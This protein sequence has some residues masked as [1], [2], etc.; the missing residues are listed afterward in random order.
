MS[1]SQP[2]I[3]GYGVG[4]PSIK[5]NPPPIISSRAPT[6]TD[7]RF[8]LGQVWVYQISSS[9]ASVYSLGSVAAGTAT[10]VL[11]GG[12]SGDVQTINNLSPT[13]GNITIAG[14]ANQVGVSNAGS[15]V[16]L[17]LPAAITAPGSL[18]TT[19]SLA[20][21]TT[22]TAG[23]GITST[24][25]NI[26]ATAGAVNAGTSMTATL[27]DITA[28]NGNLVLGT[29]G[30]KLSI[31][32]GADASTGTATL[33]GGTVTVNTTAV[34]AS[35]LI[36]IWRQSIGATGAAA[37]GELTV[38]TITAGAS[39]VINAVQAADATA[40]QA[41]DVSEIGWMIVN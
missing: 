15:T 37:L 40:L 11:L 39:F 19:T 20:A 10:W 34:T 13:N 18:T 23:T 33:S 8:P 1:S 27:G 36:H 5:L 38:G 25:G 35:S 2:R 9:N 16:T 6:S 14:T 31:A 4:A 28:T 22:I 7:I 12:A 41:T 29:A 3:T 26:V 21:T 24:T 32:T 17:S 30:N